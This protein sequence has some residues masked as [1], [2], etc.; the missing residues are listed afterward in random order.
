MIG[1][2][3]GKLR[4]RLARNL[5]WAMMAQAVTAL[6]GIVTLLVT[7]RAL[8]PAALGLLA[9]VETYVRLADRLLRLE[10]WQAFIKHAIGALERGEEAPFRRLVKLSILIDLGGSLLAGTVAIAASGWLAPRIGLPDGTGAGMVSFVAIGLFFSLRPTAIGVL[11]SFNRFDLLAK[12]DMASALLRLILSLIAWW[13]G[14]GIGGFLAILLVQSLMDGLL[15]F[16]FALRELHRRGHRR[17]WAAR[18]RQ[19]LREYP[20]FLSF[21]WNSNAN[22]ILRQSA[23]RLDII[24]LGGLMDATAVGYYQI[25]KRVMNSVVKLAGP[26]RQA[27]YP[28]MARLW[29]QNRAPDLRRLVIRLCLTALVVQLIVAL[30]AM[31]RMESLITAI[32]GPEFAAATPVMNILVSS[33]IV[34]ISGV[35]LNPALLSMGQDRALVRITLT[36]MLVYLGSFAPLVHL[37]GLRGAGA[38]NLMFN[39]AWTL[40]CVL[41]FRR[42]LRRAPDA[43]PL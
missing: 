15:A 5:S 40:G 14:W 8:G 35:A 28:E 12:A 41:V 31:A 32:F 34:F 22:V 27:I 6:T 7:A 21:L 16:G 37:F 18:A 29:S 25:G 38:S 26:F 10:P 13:A 20:G 9:L 3:R 11:R 30:P 36:A 33:A 17:I 1:R 43:P 39:L 4:S 19:A 2:L 23:N 42:Q 24:L